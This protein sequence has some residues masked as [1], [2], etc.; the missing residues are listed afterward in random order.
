MVSFRTYNEKDVRYSYARA[1]KSNQNET[2]KGTFPPSLLFQHVIP[3]MHLR[4]CKVKFFFELF[5]AIV[6]GDI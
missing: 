1:G 6:K 3:K 5:L 4:K 2:I